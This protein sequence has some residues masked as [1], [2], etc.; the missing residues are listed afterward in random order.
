MTE[1][2]N[3]IEYTV[4]NP[5]FLLILNTISLTLKAYL[6]GNLFAKGLQATSAKKAFVFL[7]IV[8]VSSMAT[9]ITWIISLARSM[10]FPNTDYRPYLF[11]VRI[12]WGFSVI[13]YQSL[14]LFLENLTEHSFKLNLRQRMSV[15][16]STLFFSF[17]V[18]LAIFNFNCFSASERPNLEF[19]IRNI[20]MYYELFFLMAPSIA[21]TLWK[22]R[23]NAVPKILKKTIESYYSCFYH[24]RLV[25]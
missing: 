25:M 17:A 24:S 18:A 19:M 5:P 15:I 1:L 4:G 23:S 12:A 10:W 16:I 6:L 14:A 9:D 11:V 20:E 3:I 2:I 22:I 13:Q 8:L 7:A 21:I